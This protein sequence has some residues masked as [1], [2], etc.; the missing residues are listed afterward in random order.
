MVRA[1]SLPL[2]VTSGTSLLLGAFFLALYGRLARRD[3]GN[4]RYYLVFALLAFVSGVFLASFAVLLNAGERML[5]LDVSNRVVV[6][7]AMF[8]ILLALEFYVSF[9]EYRPPV[10]LG[11]CHLVN[12]AFALLCLVPNRYFLAHERFPT[13]R[14][15]TG[16][17][18]GPAFQAW[19][20]W[21]IALS[22]Y[23]ILLLVL[24]HRRERRSPEPRPSAALL[25]LIAA[26]SVWLITGISDDLT[27]LQVIDLPPL[28]WVG[29]F[30]ITASIAWVLV[31]QIDRLYQERHELHD[32]LIR[33]HLTGAYSRGFFEVRLADAIGA[34]RRGASPGLV[35]CVFDVD[36]FKAV[37]D[38]FGHAAGD[39]VLRGIVESVAPAIRATDCCARLGGDEFALL[40]AGVPDESVAEF[41]VERI[42]SSI[43]GRTFGLEAVRAS[44]SFGVVHVA[45]DAAW[46]DDLAEQLLT[47]ADAALYVSKRQG[48]NRISLAA[49]RLPAR[50]LAVPAGSGGS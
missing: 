41:V 14:Y 8:T 30:L 15:Y 27:A 16:L 37:N 46:R 12:A 36:D 25:A 39:G 42:R 3:A 35:V 31:L 20:A 4:T 38:R 34:L 1:L 22:L 7:S 5:L 29:S 11:W 10:S 21:V 32:K 47:S 17:A 9:F 50:D 43:A 49:L 48:K 23:G 45:S 19:G 24:V 13:S 2:I 28:T 18:F 33:D 40:F 44:C 26:T 6:I